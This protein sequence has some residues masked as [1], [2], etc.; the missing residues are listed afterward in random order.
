MFLVRPIHS[1]AFL[2]RH[3]LG[4]EAH[5]G[6]YDIRPGWKDYVPFV[7][8]VHLPYAGFN[9]AALDR[10]LR[11]ESIRQIE[12]AIDTGCHYPVDRMVIHTAGFETLNGIKVGAYELLIES[13][14]RLASYAAKHKIILCI[15][16]QVLIKPEKRHVF[17]DN[18]A[19]WRRIY[20][21]IDCPNILLTLDTSHAATSVAIYSDLGQRL[22][23]L[24]DFLAYPELIGRIHWSDS[25][26]ENQEALYND[27]HLIPGA[28]DLP[29]SFHLRIKQLPVI[30][31]LEQNCTENEVEQALEFIAGL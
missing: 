11:E 29:R 3:A 10:I 27:M 22:A 7:R 21:D 17:G 2:V 4:V 28:G 12:V 24:E 23:A 9:V 14:Q 25:R 30:K 8:G 19:E 1:T 5:I 15:E 20:H 16:N 6:R 31:L 18:A 26:L 13:F